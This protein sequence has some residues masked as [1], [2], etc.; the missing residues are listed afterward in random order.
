[1]VDSGEA[2]GI[3]PPVVPADVYDEDYYLHSC[4]GSHEWC[5]SGGARYAGIYAG[6]LERA[7]MKPGEVLV[8]IGTG[9]GELLAAAVRAGAARAVGVEYSE[10]AVK[11][12]RQTLSTH[13]TGGRAEVVLADARDVPLP[14]SSAD[15]VTMLDVV[16]HLAPDELSA[17]FEQARRLLKPGGRLVLHTFPTSTIYNVTYRLQRAWR[18]SRRRSWPANPR[19]PLENVMHVNEQTLRSLRRALKAAKF[20]AVD[21]KFGDWVFADFVPDEKA[22]RTYHRLARS[23]LTRPLGVS[24][25][26]AE[27]R[28]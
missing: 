16:E 20:A 22:R 13:D 26:W 11:L 21:V 23:P 12:A 6:S 3:P 8:D 1:M 15:L 27:A 24:D 4:A 18:P 17:A 7:R 10:S 5:A 25:L 2:R 14:S 9:R 28:R 19:H